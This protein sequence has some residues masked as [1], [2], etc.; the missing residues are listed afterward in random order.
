M[1]TTFSDTALTF[2]TERSCRRRVGL[3]WSYAMTDPVLDDPGELL[4]FWLWHERHHTI[5]SFAVSNLAK[6]IN[7]TPGMVTAWLTRHGIPSPYW[8]PIARFFGKETY[9]QLAD[10]AVSLWAE[11]DHRRGYT[12]LHHIQVKR[13]HQS[14]PPTTV[15]GARVHP[16]TPAAAAAIGGSLGEARTPSRPRRSARQATAR[17]TRGT[18]P[19]A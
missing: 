6:A 5:R 13:R 14:A 11:A 18:R 15:R 10:A 19:D 2:Y 4:R 3:G 8:N 7:A 12:P 1:S 9:R 17:R 16:E